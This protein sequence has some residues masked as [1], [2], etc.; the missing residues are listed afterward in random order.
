ME[1][2]TDSEKEEKGKREGES[3][4]NASWTQ[5]KYS[6]KDMEIMEQRL[7]LQSEGECT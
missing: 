7:S 1:K 2:P 5:I 4:E 3:V 6:F